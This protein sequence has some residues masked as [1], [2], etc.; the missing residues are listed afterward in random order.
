MARLVAVS[1]GLLVVLVTVG[2]TG[3][4]PPPANIDG[5]SDADSAGYT[6][7]VR[8]A[9]TFPYTVT[10]EVE[11]Y[12]SGPQQGRPPDGTLPA[13]T[14]I[15]VLRRTGGYSLVRTAEGVEGYVSTDSIQDPSPDA[16]E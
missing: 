8:P 3:Q 6:S 2:C 1:L 13:G 12:K 5:G 15:N 9:E 16:L 7:R 4:S 11:Y 14:K 10:Q